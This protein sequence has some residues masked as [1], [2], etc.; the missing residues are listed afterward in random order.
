MDQAARRIHLLLMRTAIIR[1]GDA[2]DDHDEL[3]NRD[4]GNRS[5]HPMDHHT[6]AHLEIT[7]GE[8]RL[9]KSPIPRRNKFSVPP[10]PP[11]LSADERIALTRFRTFQA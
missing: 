6:V 3:D 8:A 5:G 4:S 9:N 10:A 1:G 11:G 7:R 2:G